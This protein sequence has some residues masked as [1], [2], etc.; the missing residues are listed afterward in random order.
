MTLAA[1]FDPLQAETFDSAYAQYDELRGRCPVAHT[2][3]YGGFWALARHADV[4]RVL[5]DPATYQAFVAKIPLGRW[6]NLDEIGGKGVFLASDASSFITGAG[7]TID[8]G[9]TVM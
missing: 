6:G 9:W 8:G 1:D 2:P 4:S 5:N 3:A 7:I